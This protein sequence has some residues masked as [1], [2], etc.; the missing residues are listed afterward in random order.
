MVRGHMINGYES[1]WL[2][3]IQIIVYLYLGLNSVRKAISG[4]E[5]SKEF[6][7]RFVRPAAGTTEDR[8][9][10]AREMYSKYGPGSIEV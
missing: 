6:E 9:R 10:F 7:E 8:I 5:A 1:V 2:F 3:M 4:E